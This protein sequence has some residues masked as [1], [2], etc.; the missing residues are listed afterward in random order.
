MRAPVRQEDCEVARTAEELI[1]WIESVKDLFHTDDRIEKILIKAFF[2]EIRPL[3]DLASHKYLGRPG[4]S[5]RPKIG[6]QNY[7]AE[8]IDT[9]FGDEN[10]TRV[11]FTSTY[12]DDDFALR[13]EYL[14]QHRDVY[15]TG[16]VWRDGTKA[17]GGQVQVIPEFEDHHIRL[18]KMLDT[19]KAR[20]AYK[21]GKPYT[22][23]TILAIVF[24]DTIL[25]RDTDL[26]QL[27]PRFR[28]IML[29]QQA[30]KKFCDVFII[31]ASGRTFWEFGETTSTDLTRYL[32]PLRP[33]DR[34]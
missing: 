8:I 20:V 21:L 26:P 25:Y 15:W 34:D 31:G 19:I 29:S 16:H 2:E 1:A 4:L 3:G 11:E 12:R 23:N 5:L 7:D 14:G 22:S 33:P 28:E 18:D 9:S 13:L 30:L 17:S 27:Q 6:D 32:N 24:D 10:I